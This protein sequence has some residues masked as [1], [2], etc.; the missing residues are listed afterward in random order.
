M[1]LGRGCPLS[2]HRF[3]VFSIDIAPKVQ[4]YLQFWS[5]PGEPVKWEVSS[6]RWSPP[7]DKWLAGERSRRI[8]GFGFEIGGQAE[9]F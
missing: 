4:A 6:G 5:E 7:A 2:D 8:A 3:V 1:P 9:N